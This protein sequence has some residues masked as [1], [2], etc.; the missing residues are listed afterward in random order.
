MVRIKHLG[1]Y[2]R[3]S[4]YNSIGVAVI[5]S[6]FGPLA[7]ELIYDITSYT[8]R[9]ERWYQIPHHQDISA[10]A[11][12]SYID[13]VN[14]QLD[15]GEFVEFFRTWMYYS[16]TSFVREADNDDYIRFQPDL[17]SR[18]ELDMTADCF[19]S[20]LDLAVRRPVFFVAT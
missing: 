1:D 2:S 10:A 3:L 7:C 13:N 19:V 16:D 11:I 14:P 4:L 12:M 20:F 6:P 5:D 8:A 17:M 18:I 9:I 15:K